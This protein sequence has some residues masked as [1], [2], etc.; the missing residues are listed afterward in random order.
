MAMTPM[1]RFAVSYKKLNE[2][3]TK[4]LVNLCNTYDIYKLIQLLYFASI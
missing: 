4:G 2:V 1:K 3:L